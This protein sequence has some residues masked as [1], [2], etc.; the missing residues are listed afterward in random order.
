MVVG[1]MLAQIR[2]QQ[3][4][5]FSVRFVLQSGDAV[6]AGER[7]EQWNVSFIPLIDKLTKIG[8]VPYFLVPGNHDVGTA[9]TMNAPTRQP[10][11]RNFYDAMSSL[12]PLDGSPWRFEGVPRLCIRVWQHVRSRHRF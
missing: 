10:G 4:A 5:E 3:N 8:N 2:R 1:G 7:P 11:L 9:T 6:I 12:I